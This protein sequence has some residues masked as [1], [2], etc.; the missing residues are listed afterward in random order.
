LFAV[1]AVVIILLAWVVEGQRRQSLALVAK[2]LDFAFTLGQQRLPASLDQAGFY[3]FTQGQPQILNRLEGERAGYRVM[4]FEYGYDAGKGEE[5][6]RDLPPA[7]VG[8][9]ENRLQVVVWLQ[10]TEQLLPDFDL[11]PT[12]QVIR[13]VAAK[14]SGMAQIA[15]D[16]RDAFSARYILY[17][18]DRAA[19]DRVFTRAVTGALAADPGWFIEGRGDQWLVYRLSQRPAPGQI[20]EFLN[21]AIERIDLLT[22]GQAHAGR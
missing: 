6:S 2:R 5:G 19:L 14:V 4:V 7:D 3:L 10:R 20:S 12:H 17:G 22:S 8:Q 9:S 21:Q 1:V 16:R 11:S 15:F 13:R 18:R